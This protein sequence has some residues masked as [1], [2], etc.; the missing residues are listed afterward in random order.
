MKDP[1]AH[2]RKIRSDAAECLTLSNLVTEDRRHLFARIAAHL[3]SLASEIESEAVTSVAGEPNATVN[4]QDAVVHHPVPAADQSKT[5]H[6]WNGTPW[7][8]LPFSV[9]IA[10][11]VFGV[12]NQTKKDSFSV[13]PTTKAELS[14]ATHDEITQQLAS[15]LSDE[16]EERKAIR[17]QLSALVMRLDGLAKELDDLKS[18]RA[19]AVP[20]NKG[21]AGRAIR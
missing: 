12:T 5:S 20:S 1:Q 13:V 7:L 2:V 16:K 18:F 8:L 10:G 15:F 19:L 17:E 4:K 14:A 6:S 3:N 21:A 11:A 9:V